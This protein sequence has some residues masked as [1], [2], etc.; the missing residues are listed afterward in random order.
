MGHGDTSPPLPLSAPQRVPIATNQLLISPW[1]G[2]TL[3]IQKF[4][5][6]TDFKLFV[7]QAIK[8]VGYPS[9]QKAALKGLILIQG[10]EMKNV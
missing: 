6:S 5:I 3:Q 1:E 7:L 9:L 4:V 2:C 10:D 8:S